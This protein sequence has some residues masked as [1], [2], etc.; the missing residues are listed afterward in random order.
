MKQRNKRRKYIVDLRFQGGHVLG[1]VVLVA[2]SAVI[3]GLLFACLFLYK[4]GPYKVQQS[5]LPLEGSLSPTGA[6]AQSLLS[7]DLL[8]LFLW[9]LIA[10]LAVAV[11]WAVLASHRIAGASFHIKKSLKGIAGGDLETHLRLRKKDK[12]KDLAE[13]INVLRETLR[14][15]ADE[16]RHAADEI[17]AKARDAAAILYTG[18]SEEELPR[19]LDLAL[20]DIVSACGTIARRPNAEPQKTQDRGDKRKGTTG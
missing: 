3:I 5:I 15:K 20:A 18:L 7:E 1:Y 2:I 9:M 19:K 13:E 4:A 16:D 8:I 17:A 11:V 14:E 10:L 12:L 6:E